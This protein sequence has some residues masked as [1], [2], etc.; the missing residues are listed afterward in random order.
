MSFTNECFPN[1]LRKAKVIP[2]YKTEIIKTYQ[3]IDQFQ[4]YQLSPKY[5]NKIISIYLTYFIEE[6]DLLYQGQFGIRKQH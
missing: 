4:C 2:I 5:M 1:E 3:I 6:H